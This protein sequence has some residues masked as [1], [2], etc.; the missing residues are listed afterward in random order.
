MI[1]PACGELGSA[2]SYIC[3]EIGLITSAYWRMK[4]HEDLEDEEA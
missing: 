3:G 4:K 1:T 2:A